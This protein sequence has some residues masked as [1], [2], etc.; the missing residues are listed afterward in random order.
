MFQT[1]NQ[2]CVCWSKYFWL[3]SESEPFSLILTEHFF[4]CHVLNGFK[5]PSLINISM[6]SKSQ[7]GSLLNH[8]GGTWDVW[9]HQGPIFRA[10]GEKTYPFS[11]FLTYVFF[12]VTSLSPWF[13]TSQNANKSL[14]KESDWQV[15]HCPP[16]VHKSKQDLKKRKQ[17]LPSGNQH[18][19]LE[20]L[21]FWSGSSQ[22][23]QWWNRILFTY[24][25]T[26]IYDLY[27]YIYT[28]I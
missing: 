26:T 28:Y 7:L 24:L 6:F 14:T 25:F 23:W 11:Y 10:T 18:G 1:T 4:F 21:P 9:T 15:S 2:H 8:G 3:D 5:S 12:V 27:I 19:L 13:Q 16:H 22:S 20:N 17:S